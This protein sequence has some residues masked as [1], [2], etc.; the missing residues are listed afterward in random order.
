MKKIQINQLKIRAF[1]GVLEEETISGTDFLINLRLEVNF[2]KACLHDDLEA[3]VNYDSICTYIKEEMK[4]PSKLLE[5]VLY[6]ICKRIFKE[7]KLVNKIWIELQ[8]ENPPIHA[9]IKSAGVEIEISR[10][11]IYNH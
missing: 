6:R 3:T 1:H 9:D 10:E 4:T 5:N 7:E 11:E 8:K 2:L